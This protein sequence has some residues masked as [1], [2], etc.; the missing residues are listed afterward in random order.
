MEVDLE[1]G[2]MEDLVYQGD[3][4][5]RVVRT[6]TNVKPVFISPGHKAT[7]DSAS[8]L[9]LRTVTKYRLPEPIRAAHKTAGEF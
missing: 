3:V 9:I 6:R 5:G 8:E 4:V 1:K 7:I 2:S